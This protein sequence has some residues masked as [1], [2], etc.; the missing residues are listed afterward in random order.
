MSW[1]I[2]R[3]SLFVLLALLAS[4]AAAAETHYYTVTVDYSMRW[5]WVEARFSHPVD[6]ISARSRSAG[7]F[8]ADVRGCGEDPQI[9]LRNRRLMVPDDAV[10][11]L[12]YTVDLQSAAKEYR[13]SRHLARQNIVVSPC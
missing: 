6:S 1:P 9:R 5:L 8:L 4:A 13:N 3:H 7:K 12:N 11:C 10:R 2:Y